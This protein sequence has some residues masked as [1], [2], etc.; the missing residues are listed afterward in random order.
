MGSI[1]E[2]FFIFFSGGATPMHERAPEVD[3][4]FLRTQLSVLKSFKVGK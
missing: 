1:I 3:Q 2:C 4:A